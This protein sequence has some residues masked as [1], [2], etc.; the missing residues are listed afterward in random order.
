MYV[1]KCITHTHTHTGTLMYMQFLFISAIWVALCV[2]FFFS[3]FFPSS[4]AISLNFYFSL[5][6]ISPFHAN[7]C[8]CVCGHFINA[9]VCVLRLFSVEECHRTV[10]HCHNGF[11]T[12]TFKDTPQHSFFRL[13]NIEK[14]YRLK[15]IIFKTWLDYFDYFVLLLSPQFA[16]P[17]LHISQLT[18]PASDPWSLRPV[19]RLP[20]ALPALCKKKKKE[21]LSIWHSSVK[22]LTQQLSDCQLAWQDFAGHSSAPLSC[23][24]M[25]SSWSHRPAALASKNYL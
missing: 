21:A 6:L 14:K 5:L 7:A 24:R 23:R 3:Y 10:K 8:V 11:L 16:L 1:G 4:L 9:C 25:G 2:C 22:I 15:Y 19:R 12:L 17:G 20:S 13:L 18:H